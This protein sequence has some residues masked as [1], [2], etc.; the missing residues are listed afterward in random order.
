MSQILRN[1]DSARSQ[2]DLLARLE[3]LERQMATQVSDIFELIAALQIDSGVF[4]HAMFATGTETSVTA[5]GAVQPVNELTITYDPG[6]HANTTT[7]SRLTYVTWGASKQYW[8]LGWLD[9]QNL[10]ANT[11]VGLQSAVGGGTSAQEMAR[12][13]A[14]IAGQRFNVGAWIVRGP[15]AAGVNLD[16]L[17]FNADGTTARNIGVRIAVIPLGVN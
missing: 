7:N 1:Q 5:G 9:G 2:D 10:A 4:K 6:G 16:W 14:P 17:V 11:Q 15:S 13:S 3:R 12:G 8:V